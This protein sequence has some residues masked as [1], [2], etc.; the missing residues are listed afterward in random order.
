M[1][2]FDMNFIF[3]ISVGVNI[4]IILAFIASIINR[5]FSHVETKKKIGP[6]DN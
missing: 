5:I 6:R 4:T 3:G 1:V 2:S